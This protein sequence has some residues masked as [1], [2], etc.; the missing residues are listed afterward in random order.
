MLKPL[1]ACERCYLRGSGCRWNPQQLLWETRPAFGGKELLV[2][3]DGGSL[4]KPTSHHRQIT[5]FVTGALCKGEASGT[6]PWHAL[7]PRRRARARGST[8][9]WFGLPL[10]RGAGPRGTQPGDTA[11]DRQT[12]WGHTHSPIGAA[13]GV[14]E[15]VW[16]RTSRDT[17]GM[18]STRG[19]GEAPR[20]RS[21]PLCQGRSRGS[22]TALGQTPPRT[23]QHTTTVVK[24][25]TPFL[26]KDRNSTKC[27][28]AG[29][30][31]P[32]GEWCHRPPC[33]EPRPQLPQPGWPCQHT[34][35]T[36]P[37]PCTTQGPGL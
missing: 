35:Q 22:H 7:R 26:F 11:R 23:E 19:P 16:S 10:H 8:A 34:S 5:C 15:N 20:R 2:P 3:T 36:L 25:G 17:D 31:R 14:R 9:P 21:C 27:P 13:I 32:C 1:P 4:L 29:A 12:A 30:G 24:R 6:D 28:R 18:C 37:A 33:P